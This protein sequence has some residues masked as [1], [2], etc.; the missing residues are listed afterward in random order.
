M[1][2]NDNCKVTCDLGTTGTA[3]I[4]TDILDLKAGGS[5]KELRPY[6]VGIVKKAIAANTAQSAKLEMLTSDTSA[7]IPTGA[8]L[9]QVFAPAGVFAKKGTFAKIPWPLEGVQRFVA[10]RI[11]P[12]AALTTG[13]TVEVL[14]A[15]DVA[16][17]E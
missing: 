13:V 11:T 16:L 1:I 17:G 14:E 15:A 7:G 2:L 8:V 3:G 9:A 5:N 4:I 10:F 6:F 12:S